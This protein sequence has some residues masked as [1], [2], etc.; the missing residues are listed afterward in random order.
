L[1]E[2]PRRPINTSFH[3]FIDYENQ[4]NAGRWLEMNFAGTTNHTTAPYNK[5][6]VTADVAEIGKRFKVLL[7]CFK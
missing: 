5:N 3:I 1:T 7:E 6:M 4:I 2:K